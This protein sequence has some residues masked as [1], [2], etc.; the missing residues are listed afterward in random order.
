MHQSEGLSGTNHVQL[1][2]WD[3]TGDPGYAEVRN[4]FYKDSNLLLVCYDIT[5]VQSYSAIDRWVSEVAKNGGEKMPIIICG[6]KADQK[7][8]RCMPIENAKSDCLKKEFA[9]YYETSAKM[10]E[11]FSQL[12]T[13]IKR[14]IKEQKV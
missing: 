6:T 7:S 9:E 3:L 2:F 8:R 12:I 10:P 14:V 5:D 4:E 1:T 11:G 13:G